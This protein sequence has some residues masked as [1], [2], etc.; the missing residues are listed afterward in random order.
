M[1]IQH[2]QTG[3]KGSFY[4]EGNGERQAEMTYVTAGE[5]RIIIDHTQ[6]DDALRGKG[7]GK[8]MVAAAVDYARKNKI[9]ILP[10]CPFA[11]AVFDKTPEYGDVLSK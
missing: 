4:V 8:Q 5:G 2:E 9:E 6:V 1:Q 10:L 11:K 7:A 3:H